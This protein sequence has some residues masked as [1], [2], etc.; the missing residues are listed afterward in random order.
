M[1]TIALGDF[2]LR[3]GLARTAPLWLTL[4]VVFSH[5]P[6]AHAVSGVVYDAST[7]EPIAGAE[8]V[9]L[10]DNTGNPIARE[11]LGAGQQNQRTGATGDYQFDPPAGAYR[12]V[13]VPPAGRFE[14]PSRARP[15][16]AGSSLPFGTLAPASLEPIVGHPVPSATLPNG[17]FLRVQSSGTRGE[18]PNNHLPVDSVAGLL[19]V[20]HTARTPRIQTGE[21]AA[22]QLRLANTSRTAFPA[23]SLGSAS[24]VLSVPN[25]FVLARDSVVLS[26]AA[27][28]SV[29]RRFTLS[30]EET[31]AGTVIL[32]PI[33][34]PAQ[35]T[36]VISYMAVAGANVRPDTFVFNATYRTQASVVAG[37][38]AARLYVE[39]DAIFERSEVIGRVFCDD[40][41]DGRVSPR[42]RGLA[43]AR[44]YLDNGS[45]AVTD[46]HGKF[47]FSNVAGGYHLAKVDENTVPPGSKPTRTVRR[48][49]HLTPGLPAKL[50]FGFACALDSIVLIGDRGAR[51]P[52][53][54][55]IGTTAPLG[56]SIGERT[57]AAGELASVLSV[58]A[59]IASPY[60]DSDFIELPAT[61]IDDAGAPTLPALT[62]HIKAELPFTPTHYAWLVRDARDDIIYRLDGTG[63]P[64]PA[65]SID[66]KDGERSA[67]S[68]GG[69]Y[70]YELL[71]WNETLFTRSAQKS[72][73]I[74]SPEPALAPIA[75]KRGGADKDA[76]AVLRGELFSKTNRPTPELNAKLAA[77]MDTLTRQQGVLVVEA[78]IANDGPASER[79]AVTDKRAQAVKA[80]LVSYGIDGQRIIA[81]GRGDEEPLVPNL[82]VK[83]REQNRRI[84]IALD[85]TAPASQPASLPASA[86]ASSPA[87]E[88]ASRPS[89]QPRALV[90][91]VE[92]PMSEAGFKT[93]V[94]PS[95]RTTVYM[96]TQTGRAFSVRDGYDPASGQA[97]VEVQGAIGGTALRLNGQARPQPVMG[98][99]CALLAKPYAVRDGKLTTPLEFVFTGDTAQ[100]S[101][102]RVGLYASND[103]LIQMVMAKDKPG[104]APGAVVLADNATL[105]A[106]LY[107][108]RCAAK[109]AAGSSVMT[110]PE[111][112]SLSAA[113]TSERVVR[114]ALFTGREV[115]PDLKRA[116][117]ALVAEVGPNAAI[118]V[119][120]HTGSQSGADTR[121]EELQTLAEAAAAV[122][123]LRTLGVNNASGKGMGKSE[124]LVPPIG[125]KALEQNRRVVLRVATA[126][127]A[128]SGELPAMAAPRSRRVRVNGS[129]VAVDAQGQFVHSFIALDPTAGV[130]I[131][132]DDGQGRE[133]LL[134]VPLV[135]PAQAAASGPVV[136]AGRIPFAG[137]PTPD[138]LF[139]ADDAASEEVTAAALAAAAALDRHEDQSVTLELPPD[140]AVI[141]Q[142]HLIVTV[143]GPKGTVVSFAQ[144][145]ASAASSAPTSAAASTPTGAARETAASASLPAS[146]DAALA[147]ASG[148][149]QAALAAGPT[150]DGAGSASLA[151]S[152][153]AAVSAPATAVA[154]APV[155]GA[156]DNVIGDDG[157]LS[158]AVPLKDGRNDVA[159]S[160]ATPSGERASVSRSYVMQPNRW[161]LL[162]L[163]EGL[164]G[165]AG[166]QAMLPETDKASTVQV[167]GGQGFL[168]GRAV[169]YFKG[170]LKGD[171]FFKNNRLTAYVDTAFAEQG[172]FMRN[173]IEPDRFYPI[174]GD[175]SEEVQDARQNKLYVMLEAD[176]S[177]LEGGNVLTKLQGIELFRYD[178][179]LFGARV[180][181]D[182]SFGKHDHTKLTAFGGQPLQSSRR[183]HTALRGTGGALYF[184]RDRD[185]VEG[186]EQVRLVVRDAVSGAVVQEVTKTRNVDYTI[187]YDTGRVV[188]LEPV[189]AYAGSG[190][191]GARLTPLSVAAGNAVYVEVDYEARDGGLGNQFAVGGYIKE[192]LFGK[193]TLGGGIVNERRG[194]GSSPDY[195]LYGGSVAV[196]PIPGIELTGELNRSEGRD[197]DL[198]VT[199]DGGQSFADVAKP[200]TISNSDGSLR[201]VTGFA[202]KATAKVDFAKVLG[203]EREL[204]TLSGYAQRIDPNYYASGASFE[205]GQLKFGAAVRGAITKKD[206]LLAR[207]DG[208]Y[209]DLPSFD[210]PEF[211][212][213]RMNRQLTTA[214][215]EHVEDKWDVGVLY[216]HGFADDS[217]TLGVVN[218]DTVNLRGSYKI[219][220]KLTVFATQEFILQADPAFISKTAD[221]FA[222]EVGLR[223]QFNKH[224]E[225]MISETVR[226]GGSNATTVGLRTPFGEDGRIYVNERF[227]RDLGGWTTTTIV[228]GENSIA[229]G[230]RAYGEYQMD[231]GAYGPHA[232]AVYGLNNRWELTRGLY[233]NLLYERSQNIGNA[234]GVGTGRG[235]ELGGLPVLGT[236][237][238]VGQGS[239]VLARDRAFYNPSAILGLQFPVGVAS[240][241]AASAG[242]EWVRW[243]ALKLTGRFEMRFDNQDFSLGGLDR[244]TLF[245]TFGVAAQLHRDL[246]LLGRLEIVDARERGAGRQIA[247]LSQATVGMAYRPVNHDYFNALVKYTHRDFLRPVDLGNGKE[248]ERVDVVSVVPVFEIPY[249][250]TQLVEKLALKV[251]E[252]A[253]DDTTRSRNTTLLLINRVNVHV[254]KWLDLGGEYRWRKSFSTGTAQ[255]GFLAEVMVSPWEYVRL[256]VGYNF[257]HFSDDE[258]A[259]ERID[260]R[261]FFIRAVAK[262]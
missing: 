174:Y 45:Y 208:I 125:K 7:F 88:P 131:A 11:L 244:T 160:V 57:F 127:S 89:L 229:R 62:L 135:A 200:Q 205:Q 196:T 19:R 133:T 138:A 43:M 212:L 23:D 236:S 53:I 250:R 24:V 222:T 145:G 163:G 218:T 84:V 79:Q 41:G 134:Q 190:S 192:T 215:Y 219:T 40:D 108:Y 55:V 140:G 96:Q 122:A 49:F 195:R 253:L 147:S 10:S 260:N 149:S 54:D 168:H 249:I 33:D 15:L 113:S 144:A 165:Q 58:D 105:E 142:D 216:L 13:V 226:Y 39:P 166:A 97:V 169:L 150:S 61:A 177:K 141:K 104:V 185:I 152:S 17:Y 173:V 191:L 6:V 100:L 171:W 14:F 102:V 159:L 255:G 12:I 261:G 225:G 258:L 92:V 241:D 75:K 130:S 4:V 238:F 34:V 9:L 81:R 51:G 78:H 35:T 164:A 247:G 37:P 116:L 210:S 170:Q 103:T 52:T 194:D 146:M 189:A 46:R 251:Q 31:R 132:I 231:A 30:T 243:K 32:G 48:D 64:P 85:K 93:Q 25:G 197:T 66:F 38:L 199:V 204:V 120:A 193:V 2:L 154:S 175:A 179:A 47:H 112:F 27:T 186:S 220:P 123:Y 111:L 87:S 18:Q 217:A 91:G 230:S 240:R 74:R 59:V 70:A 162:A 158:L 213:R 153:D 227:G 235:A 178:R 5:Q 234:T 28:G 136:V 224:L 239:G 36:Y 117:D 248:Q 202:M 183:V 214:G 176:D 124:P 8:L 157:L 67:I 209:S 187:S 221:R 180:D 128:P 148:P 188:F 22:L 65:L 94:L 42:E 198:S 99:G 106:G 60:W 90:H 110:A 203:F 3:S 137:E 95:D 207:H 129:D 73:V 114:G 228:G 156:G 26:N 72:F 80:L 83:G 181:F 151:A 155:P 50:D 118:T 109:D 237:T 246:S 143:R 44:V 232:R 206:I 254:L 259:D 161:F 257:T 233:V 98:F 63:A 29:V 82:G 211:S 256:G 119:E 182:R 1:G 21:V 262:Y 16:G 167:L 245:G 172:K 252:L 69:P 101:D 68:V 56:V 86:A 139:R 242:I 107:N 184:M 71:A 76:L 201:P 77:V 121:R 126:A 223:Y 115:G 20:T